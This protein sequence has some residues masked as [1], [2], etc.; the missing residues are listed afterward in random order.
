M[1]LYICMY[2]NSEVTL[3]AVL[4]AEHGNASATSPQNCDNE[5]VPD[6]KGKS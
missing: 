1:C 3:G 4:Q 5:R 6:G 2:S